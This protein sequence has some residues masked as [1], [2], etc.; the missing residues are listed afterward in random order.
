MTSRLNLDEFHVFCT[1]CCIQCWYRTHSMIWTGIHEHCILK[2]DIYIYWREEGINI[3]I[4][5]WLSCYQPWTPWRKARIQTHDDTTNYYFFCTICLPDVLPAR[6]IKDQKLLHNPLSPGAV[7]LV[8]CVRNNI[9]LL[10]G[11]RSCKRDTLDLGELKTER[12]FSVKGWGER[13]RK[14]LMSTA[15]LFI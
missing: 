8:F 14:I 11:L 12:V 7:A 4:T 9:W 13:E 5:I 15:C 10:R 3:L 2:F 6:R 1:Q